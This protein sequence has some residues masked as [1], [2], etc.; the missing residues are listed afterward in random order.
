MRNDP[1][2]LGLRLFDALHLLDLHF[3]ARDRVFA[4]GQVFL[5]ALCDASALSDSSVVVLAAVREDFIHNRLV[6]RKLLNAIITETH[7]FLP[8]FFCP[9]PSQS[10]RDLLPFRR[11]LSLLASSFYCDFMRIQNGRLVLAIRVGSPWFGGEVAGTK[12]LC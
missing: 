10:S 9:F 3:G 6:V 4:T 12:S 5:K 2:L 1:R 7:G 8:H 11:F